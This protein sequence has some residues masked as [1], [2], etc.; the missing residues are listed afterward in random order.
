MFPYPFKIF[1]EELPEDFCKHVLALAE[2]AQIDEE[3]AVSC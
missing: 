1:Q 3:A 2:S